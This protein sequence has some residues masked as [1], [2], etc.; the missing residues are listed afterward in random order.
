MTV[1]IE[2]TLIN[3]LDQLS[4]QRNQSRSRI[5]EE[6]VKSWQLSQIEHEL[7]SGYQEMAKENLEMAEADFHPGMLDRKP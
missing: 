7:I 5:V 3:T 1:T 6:A 4:E 2:K